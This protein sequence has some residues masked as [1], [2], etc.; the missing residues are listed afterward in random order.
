MTDI[1]LLT[2]DLDNTLWD[3]DKVIIAAEADM[4]SWM[5]SNVPAVLDHY[6]QENTA[7]F[8]QEVIEQFPAKRHDL[9]FMRIQ[10]LNLVMRAAGFDA[11]TAMQ[12]AQ[13]AFAVFFTGRNKVEFFPDALDVLAR[14][15]QSYSLVAL[16]NG[17]A[18]IERTGLSAYFR[19]AYSS[20][21]VGASKP[22]PDMFEAALSAYDVTASEA[23][24]IGDNPIDDID[25]A[26]RVGMHT[27]WVNLRAASIEDSAI[28][29]REITALAQLPEAIEQ[30]AAF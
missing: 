18:D 1:Q 20:A 11:D 14:L 3:V 13:D 4:R 16:T 21:D 30:I 5:H 22:S 6:T 9:S 28:P 12:H 26:A 17:N 19:D 15:A 27:V 7:R 8:R 2:F 29:T 25:G 24:H 10:V 23:I